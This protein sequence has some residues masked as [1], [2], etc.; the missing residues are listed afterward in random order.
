MYYA[1]YLGIFVITANMLFCKLNEKKILTFTKQVKLDT[2]VYIAEPKIKQI[3]DSLFV[4][5]VQSYQIDDKLPDTYY[6][7]LENIT[8]RIKYRL[9]LSENMKEEEIVDLTVNDSLIYVLYSKKLMIFQKEFSQNSD[10]YVYCKKI[11]QK[12][13]ENSYGHVEF[14]FNK[15]LLYKDTYSNF[16][17][18]KEKQSYFYYSVFDFDNV[19][20]EKNILPLNKGYVFANFKPKKIFFIKDSNIFWSDYMEYN[21]LRTNVFTNQT[22]QL[23]KRKNLVSALD[24]LQLKQLDDIMSQKESYNGIFELQFKYSGYFRIN[25]INSLNDSVFAVIYSAENDPKNPTQNSMVKPKLYLD[26]WKHN[27]DN[28]ELVL[29]DLELVSK[30]QDS[31]FSESTLLVSCD[32]Y[33]CKNKLYV[34][35]NKYPFEVAQHLNKSTTKEID[36]LRE[37]YATENSNIIYSLLEFE[38]NY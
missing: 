6:N 24:S 35:S 23:N 14:V 5:Q 38:I 12:K 22:I 29:N 7:I 26:I 10:G 34:F 18:N 8:S 25:F 37:E 30:K 33:L 1:L 28:C 20:I 36:S 3:K 15:L 13:L 9:V 11:N 31:I 16:K 19:K 27:K 17:E 2:A 21:L 4:L 32:F